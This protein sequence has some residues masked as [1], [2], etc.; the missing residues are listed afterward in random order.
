MS[1]YDTPNTRIG[2]SGSNERNFITRSGLAG[3][4]MAGTRNRDTRV[5]NNWIG[6]S[7]TGGANAVGVALL[8]G[9]YQNQIGGTGSNEGNVISANTQHAVH[10]D[11]GDANSVGNIIGLNA[12]RTQARGNGIDGVSINGASTHTSV[13]NNVIAHSGSMGIYANGGSGHSISGNIIGLRGGANNSNDNTAAAN[14]GGVWVNN[15]AGVSIVG[16]NR[17]AGNTGFGI[18]ISGDGADASVIRGNVIGLSSG[19]ER[20]PNSVG[21]MI[22]AGAD[23]TIVGGAN[24]SDRNTISGN[25]YEG[26]RIKDV[27][28]KHS[29]VRG[30][31]VGTTPDG[32][33]A[34]HNASRGV[35]IDSGASASE[36][37]GNL[38]S[39]NSWDGVALI[40]AGS[41]TKVQG[42]IIGLSASGSALPNSAS[43]IAIVSATTGA[44]IGNMSAPNTIAANGSFGIYLA[45]VGT[46]GNTISGNQIGVATAGL[47]NAAGGIT[48]RSAAANN[49]VSGNVVVGHSGGPGIEI[50]GAHNN[51]LRANRVGLTAGGSSFGNQAGVRVVGGATGNVI[52][53]SVADRNY[54]SGNTLYG[55]GLAEAGTNNNS[56]LNNYI[57]VDSAGTSA[58][59]NGIGVLIGSGAANNTLTLNL[60]SGNGSLE[61]VW[62][63]ARGAIRIACSATASAWLRPAQRSLPTPA[64]AFTSPTTPAARW[65]AACRRKF[66]QWQR[67][68]RSTRAVRRGQRHQL[69]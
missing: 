26:V 67:W 16:G 34:A 8:A 66:H 61:A 50:I 24:V 20:R 68:C 52:G 44:L 63:R 3:V 38:I 15:V 43:G 42:N 2:G 23:D 59:A 48:L 6:L 41:P 28:T 46:N 1:V 39:G 12:A 10:I 64:T 47:G 60:I 13:A 54:L 55:L 11:A 33:G 37:I 30:N 25:T 22:E 65:S 58:R 29:I 69:Q 31:H 45:D 62:C 49:T 32:L 7:Q 19:N 14:G 4:Y 40:G 51:T 17:I 9:A 36:V 56:A 27:G 5:L 21:I 35:R 57:G 53:G 18:W